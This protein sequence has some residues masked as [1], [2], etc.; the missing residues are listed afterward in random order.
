MIKINLMPLEEKKDGGSKISVQLPTNI[1]NILLAIPIVIT[2]AMVGFMYMKMENRKKALTEEHA[3]LEVTYKKLQEEIK[4]VKEL[5]AKQALLT[6]RLETI[7]ALNSNR[8]YWENVLIEFA[9]RLP[10]EFISFNSCAD[11]SDEESRAMMV[12]GMALSDQ[13][14]SDY[15]RNLRESKYVRD[16]TLFGTRAAKFKGRDA[17]SF[18]MMVLLTVPVDSTQAIPEDTE[19]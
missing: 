7:R 8:D 17:R 19:S 1:T 9:N 18:S 14:I 16:V 15:I 11:Q 5:E 10:E 6:S 13:Y 4:I 3:Q 2:I 12:D